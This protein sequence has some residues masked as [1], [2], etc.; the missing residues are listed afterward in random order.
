MSLWVL[1]L[2]F[3]VWFLKGKKSKNAQMYLKPRANVHILLEKYT[4]NLWITRYIFCQS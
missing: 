3:I 4:N 1:I 2:Q